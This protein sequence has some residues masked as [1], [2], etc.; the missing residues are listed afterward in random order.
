M[1]CPHCDQERVSEIGR[2]PI[3]GAPPPSVPTPTI[4]PKSNNIVDLKS[5]LILILSIV[6]VVLAQ[7]QTKTQ[8]KLTELQQS[9]EASLIDKGYCKLLDGDNIGSGYVQYFRVV[10]DSIHIQLKN[11]TNM[12]V[13]PRIKIILLDKNGDFCGWCSE[14]WTFNTLKPGEMKNVE[15]YLLNSSAYTPAYYPLTTN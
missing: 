7:S 12:A 14:S 11:E 1:R 8:K 5:V 2:C 3:C 6:I 4:P 13:R 10:N 9:K 15:T